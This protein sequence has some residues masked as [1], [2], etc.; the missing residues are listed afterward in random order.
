MLMTRRGGHVTESFSINLVGGHVLL[1]VNGVRTL[2]DTGSQVSFGNVASLTLFGR[3]HPVPRTLL[4]RVSID[5]LRDGLRRHTPVPP[6][7]D[8]DALLGVDLLAGTTIEL[9]W[10]GGRLRVAGAGP[11][12]ATPGPPPLLP[13]ATIE[14]NGRRVRA[15]LDTGAWRSYLLPAVAEGLQRTGTFEDYNPVFGVIRPELV[16]AR[17]RLRGTEK[18]LEVGVAPPELAMV[19]HALRASVLLGNDVLSAAGTVRMAIGSGAPVA[20]EVDA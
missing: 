2:L 4:G 12:R 18:E 17:M 13:S 10:A 19:L 5:E 6:S 16:H 15:A 7:F 1:D 11:R 20:E 9:D 8:F 3:E 14:V